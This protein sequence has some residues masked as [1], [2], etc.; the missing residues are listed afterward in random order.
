MIKYVSKKIVKVA[1]VFALTCLSFFA[2]AQSINWAQAGPIYAAGRMRCMIIDKSDPSGNTMYVGSTT[3]GVFK[4]TNAGVNWTGLT[5]TVA[6]RVVS[7]MA[8]AN[9]NTIYVATGE[10]FLRA[11]ERLKSQPGTGLYKITGTNLTQVANAAVT[12][13]AITKVACS[14]VNPQ[15][16]AIAGNLGILISSNGGST[17]IVAPGTPTAAD[18]TG[19]DLKFDSNGILYCTVGNEN[20][21]APASNALVSSKVYRSSDAALSNFTDIT[22]PAM[23]AV[24]TTDYGRIELAIAP[25][26]NNVIYASCANK[27]IS[28]N[29]ASS[30]TKGLFVS[31]D[32]G[33]TWALIHVGSA[34]LDALGNGGTAA[35]GDKS[36]CIIVHPSNSDLILIGSYQ[37]YAWQRNNGSNSNP[38]GNWAKI[39][40]NL[41]PNTQLYLH[42]NIHDIKRVGSTGNEKY[43]LVTD[44]GIYRSV[45]NLFT[46]QP[47]Y[48]GIVTGQFNNVSIERY[49][50][51]VVP[52]S[53]GSSVTPYSGFIGG[54]AN[55]GLI[56]FSGNYPNVSLENSFI[57]GEVDAAE[58][59]KILP[60]VAYASSSD[61]KL[62]LNSDVKTGAFAQKDV[63]K[64]T[65]NTSTGALTAQEAISFANPGYSVTGTPLKMWENYGQVAATPDSVVFYNDS[66]RLFASMTGVATL[67]TQTTFSFSA[68]RPNSFALIDSIVVR[69]GTVVLP[70]TAGKDSPP[71]TGSDKKDITIKLSNSYLIAPTGTTAIISNSLSQAGPVVSPSTS[72]VFNSSTLQDNIN[73]TFNAPPF[74]AKTTPSSSNVPDFAAYYRV[75]CTVFYKYKAGDI[76]KVVDDRISTKTATYTAALTNSLGWVYDGATLSSFTMSA[77]NA[78]A[79]TNPTFVLTS[80]GTTVASS[81]NQTFTITP[82]VSTAYSITAYGNYTASAKPVS[83][84]IVAVPGTGTAAITSPSYVLTPGNFTQ[85]AV[86]FSV[87]PAST[88]NYTI[89]EIGTGTLTN[90]TFSTINT[91]T[92]VLN[93]G[94]ITQSTP[95][96]TITVPLTATVG[97]YTIQGLSS[98]TLTGANTTSNTTSLP[99]RTFST[100]GTGTLPP[101]SK[102][103][104]P[105]KIATAFSSR[106]A[107]AGVQNRIY[108]STQALSLNDPLSSVCVS[109]SVAL[110]CDATGAKTN[111]LITVVGKPTILEWSKSGSE[112]YYA[113]DANNLYRVSYLHTLLDSTSRNY[114]GKLHTNIYKFQASTTSNT[115]PNS[116]YRTT[117]IGT[118]T[119]GITSINVAESNTLMVV[120][121]NDP[122]GT[123]VMV[124]TGNIVTTNTS[125]IGFVTAT[126]DLITNSGA[127]GAKVNCALIEKS[128]PNQ[129]VF[130]GTDI[131]L[132]YTSNITAGSPS[133]SKVVNVGL[134]DAQVFDIKQQTMSPWDCYNS[135]QIYVATNGRGVWYTSNFFTPQVISVKENLSDKKAENNLSLYPNPTSTEVFVNFNA[136]DGETANVNIMDITGKVVV[137]QYIGKLYNG[138]VSV[139][140]EVSSLTSGIYMVNVT[141]TS[142][143]KR[144]AKLIVTK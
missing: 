118:F 110:T 45:D 19:Q 8:Q 87:T 89:L 4:S 47:F 82:V 1:G 144:V 15:I 40:T 86:V 123:P 60:S 112:L 73:V 84:T 26:N 128:Q 93:P 125:N 7:Y 117:L 140:V 2:E 5:S 30:T 103:N 23:G 113:T 83:H 18:I 71:F 43:Y 58:L 138:E 36:H 50:T 120:T 57:G 79:V 132:F 42:E 114:N 107:Y 130:V 90:S 101:I 108:V 131:G 12:G 56:Y 116:P 49:P 41:A 66:L 53:S 75:F 98:N 59:S 32:A 104:S 64:N 61:G 105:V 6:D 35:S 77:T 25:S 44:A 91:S 24:S 142:G 97:T 134:P 111:S 137:T 143:V 99:V 31:Y 16:I 122:L 38:I 29:R 9:D 62:W 28:T 94:S 70:I 54:T 109:A 14:P 76:V 20:G 63:V 48:Q 55:A 80:P 126:G 65:Y 119:A 72:I 139:P 141:S 78:T 68:S 129:K 13:T 21:D 92:Y 136:V 135:G 74:L 127:A 88:T 22:P 102:K 69:T 85:T 33:T 115:N 27:F 96:F 121:L 46:F 106:L 124:S 34:Q 17:F 39:G 11:S 133:W 52:S 95:V 67:T 37:L 100:L 10:G 3:S 81:S 51:G